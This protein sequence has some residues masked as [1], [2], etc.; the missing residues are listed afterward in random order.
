V[1]IRL[2]PLSRRWLSRALD[3]RRLPGI[4]LVP[5]ESLIKRPPPG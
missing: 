4:D 5:L 3:H 1:W 2:T